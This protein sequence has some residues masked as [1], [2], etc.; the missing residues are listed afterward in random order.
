MKSINTQDPYKNTVESDRMSPNHIPLETAL[1]LLD[2]LEEQSHDPM[3]RKEISMFREKFLQMKE[4]GVELSTEVVM[5]MFGSITR[6]EIA[7]NRIASIFSGDR[8]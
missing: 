2:T 3:L 1:K 4:N 5:A 8:Q 7:P 6:R